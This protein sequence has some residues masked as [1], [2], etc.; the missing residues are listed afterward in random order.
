MA[1]RRRDAGM[2]GTAGERANARPA[3]LPRP[4]RFGESPQIPYNPDSSH[5]PCADS[6]INRSRFQE[7]ER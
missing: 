7:Y 3:A 1:S 5:A 2:A 4:P 6:L